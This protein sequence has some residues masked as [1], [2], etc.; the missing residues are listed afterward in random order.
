MLHGIEIRKSLEMRDWERAQQ[1]IREWEAKGLPQPAEASEL[2]V[3]LACTR[4]VADAKSR[5]LRP[6]TLKK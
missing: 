3:D 4:F 5:G 2:T 6:S 1:T